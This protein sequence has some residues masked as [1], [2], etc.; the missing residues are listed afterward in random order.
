MIDTGQYQ[1]SIKS[2]NRLD[3]K[4]YERIF[5]VFT[6]SL[7]NKSFYVYNILKNI[8]FP[9][10][11]SQYIEF[12]TTPNKMPMTL[13]SYKLYGDIKSWW[14]I[15]LLNKDK[16]TGAPFFVD[17]GIQLKFITDELRTLIYDDITIST[18]YNGKK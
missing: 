3:I 4:N 6:E 9:T 15:Y 17:G 11:D 13:L 7:D 12:Y 18:I 8:E 2:L 16:F 10:I 14:I 5:K 1:N